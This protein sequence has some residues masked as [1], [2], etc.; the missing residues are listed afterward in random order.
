MLVLIA[1][2]ESFLHH[3][4]LYV[5][6]LSIVHVHFSINMLY[7]IINLFISYFPCKCVSIKRA[8]TTSP[9]YCATLYLWIP[10]PSTVMFHSLQSVFG[11][12]LFTWSNCTKESAWQSY[13]EKCLDLRP[14]VYSLFLFL[15]YPFTLWRC[16]VLQMPWLLNNPKTVVL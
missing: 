12:V 10:N 7:F 13:M 15:L 1:S 14:S 4:F 3:V 16:T 11:S 6:L 9:L 8:G 2:N 5:P